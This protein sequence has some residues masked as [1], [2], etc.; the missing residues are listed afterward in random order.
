MRRF[1]PLFIKRFFDWRRF[2]CYLLTA[3]VTLTT[4]TLLL[5]IFV[6]IILIQMLFLVLHGTLLIVFGISI[7]PSLIRWWNQSIP[8][9]L[10]SQEPLPVFSALIY[11]PL[12]SKWHPLLNELLNWK[13]ILCTPFSAVLMSVIL[14]ALAPFMISSQGFGIQK[15]TIW[16]LIFINSKRLLKN[17]RKRG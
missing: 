15:I 1:A 12:I 16:I 3:T 9:M 11:C 17:L 7:S 13:S 8:N 10:L 14:P 2:Y 4:R 5:K 6:N